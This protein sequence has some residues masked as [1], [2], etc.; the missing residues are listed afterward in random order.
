MK[1]GDYYRQNKIKYGK[2]SAIKRVF[3][4]CL[5]KI[6]GSDKYEVQLL[7][8]QEELDTL[9]YFLNSYADVSK[10]K[11]AKGSLR[12]LQEAEAVL[13]AIIDKLCGKYH[14]QY[15]MSWGTLL[16]AIRHQGFVPWDD[17]IDIG[18][19]IE[20]YNVAIKMFPKELDNFGIDYIQREAMGGFGI[21][22]KKS[23]IWLDI[24]PNYLVDQDK[25]ASFDDHIKKYRTFII[26][27]ILPIER[28][29]F[30]GFL[31]CAPNNP[32]SVLSYLYGDYM[33]F[34]KSGVYHHAIIN[35]LDGEELVKLKSEL[36][37]IY[38]QI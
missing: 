19:P 16:G 25:C 31:L 6:S 29:L 24:F 18:M 2:A 3:Q 5:Q 13:L 36:D 27:D 17:D 21:S 30:E 37:E 7:K 4:H 23:G 10:A 12:N 14:L 35:S 11:P 32:D 33:C 26:K 38:N 15:W 20:D 34:P 8:Q 28:L 9:F 1:I 22:Y